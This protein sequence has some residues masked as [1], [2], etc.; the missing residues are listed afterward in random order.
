MRNNTT[1]LKRKSISIILP[2]CFVLSAS[3]AIAAPQGRQFKDRAVGDQ[4]QRQQPPPRQQLREERQRERMEGQFGRQIGEGFMGG[5]MQARLMARVLKLTPDQI[6]R[7][8]QLRRRSIDEYVSLEEQIMTKRQSLEKAIYNETFNEEEVKQIAGELGRLE[9]QRILM[10]ARI[11]SQ[12]RL[13]LTPDQ[14]RT[15]NELRS[16]AIAMPQ[17]DN[18]PEDEPEQNKDKE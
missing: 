18:K 3:A 2:L 7:M 8:Q 15:I 6:K 12:I 11:Q 4:T 14:I 5:G 16:G 10:R 1:S 17:M 9:G 13:L